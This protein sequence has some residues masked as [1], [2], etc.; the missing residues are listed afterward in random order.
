ML[1]C[2]CFSFLIFLLHLRVFTYVTRVYTTGDGF[3]VVRSVCPVALR[4]TTTIERRTRISFYYER[5]L[6]PI[7]GESYVFFFL[8]L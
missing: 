2:E 3:I 4:P 1:R 6:Y 8:L 5:Y 7:R